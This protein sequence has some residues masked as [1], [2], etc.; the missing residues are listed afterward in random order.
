MLDL[1]QS[2]YVNCLANGVAIPELDEYKR[3]REDRE[4]REKR[5]D[6]GRSN[7]LERTNQLGLPASKPYVNPNKIGR[8]DPC[9]CGSGKKY[10]KCCLG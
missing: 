8:N 1:E 4:A 9:P 6:S 3:K 5:T 7:L 2:L 10:K